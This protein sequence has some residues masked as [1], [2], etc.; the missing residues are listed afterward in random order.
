MRDCP[1]H[2]SAVASLNP[3]FII[4]VSFSSIFS[5][6]PVLL[7]L[8]ANC[9]LFHNIALFACL[10]ISYFDLLISR[11]RVRLSEKYIPPAAGSLA[12]INSGFLAVISF[13]LIKLRLL[14]RYNLL[15]ITRF[16]CLYQ[17]VCGN[18]RQISV[19]CGRSFDHI[20]CSTVD[21]VL[22]L[23]IISILEQ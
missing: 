2:S 7:A 23:C 9:I 6:F 18:C 22:D 4:A 16:L 15:D 12:C 8:L 11:A 5:A 13:L 10:L 14:N 1:L 19:P 21:P 3:N 17:C 20:F